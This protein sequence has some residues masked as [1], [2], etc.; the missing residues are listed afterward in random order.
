MRWP[1]RRS[2]TR[3]MTASAMRTFA[4]IDLSVDAVPDAT[5]LLKFRHLLEAHELTARIFAEVG[6]L[7]ADLKLLMRE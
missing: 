4:G 3:A 6:A 1:M 2:K 7:L 5:T